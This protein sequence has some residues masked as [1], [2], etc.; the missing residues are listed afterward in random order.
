MPLEFAKTPRPI[1]KLHPGK[2]WAWLGLGELPQIL[3]F[4]Y[5]IFATAGASDFKFGAQLGFAKARRKTTPIEKEALPEI[6]GFP[7]NSCAT[8][9][10]ATLN[11][12]CSYGLPR[13]T[14]K[15]HP[16]EKR[17]VALD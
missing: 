12:P 3:G 2:Q 9:K 11:L 8:A 7:F 10:L 14:I 15:P 17:G 13:P 6:L 1:T 5:N 4:P 16:E